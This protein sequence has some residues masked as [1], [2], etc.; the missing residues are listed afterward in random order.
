MIIL[1]Q[2]IDD[3][4]QHIKKDSDEINR[5]KNDDEMFATTMKLSETEKHAFKQ[6]MDNVEKII[7]TLKKYTESLLDECKNIDNKHP[8]IYSKHL[9]QKNEI[10]D[11]IS[12]SSAN[13]SN[14]KNDLKKR[15]EE[16][17]EMK[18]TLKECKEMYSV[19]QEY[20]EEK[21]TYLDDLKEKNAE[22]NK[23]N[24]ELVLKI[25]ENEVNELLLHG[26]QND[27]LELNEKMNKCVEMHNYKM[28]AIKVN[29][30]EKENR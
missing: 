9:N 12:K 16:L 19:S 21:T 18:K 22:L 25:A 20:L 3:I 13:I 24:E 11:R 1:E 27:T 8:Y 7:I 4:N 6:H 15:E 30:A 17:E 26:K 10:Q 23:R 28:Q 14:K 5:L 29:I 2:N